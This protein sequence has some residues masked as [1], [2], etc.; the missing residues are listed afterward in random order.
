MVNALKKE[1]VLEI[2]NTI[3]KNEVAVLLNHEILTFKNIEKARKLSK[4]VK[5]IKFK[6]RLLKIAL[7]QESKCEFNDY[8]KLQKLLNF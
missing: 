7:E 5:I 6:N 1:Q 8:L 4:N 2:K 3:T